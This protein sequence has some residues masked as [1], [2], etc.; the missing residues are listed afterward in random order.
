MRENA[1]EGW[2]VV[3]ARAKNR[4]RPLRCHRGLHCYRSHWRK[5]GHLCTTLHHSAG[6][7]WSCQTGL[8]PQKKPPPRDSRA[9][10][11][12]LR[13]SVHGQTSAGGRRPSIYGPS[14]V[15][16]PAGNAGPPRMDRHRP[17][18][19]GGC[20]PNRGVRGWPRVNSPRRNSAISLK[21]KAALCGRGGG[22]QRSSSSPKST[23]GTFAAVAAFAS[24]SCATA[25]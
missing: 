13:R 16:G 9:A 18:A 19:A 7:S 2:T 21:R 22:A 11:K 23:S 24:S 8:I 4:P 20:P 14:T 5:Q 6:R 17:Q 25:L 3:V 10:A 1:L 12:T 15:Q